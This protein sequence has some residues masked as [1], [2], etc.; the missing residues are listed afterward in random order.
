MMQSQE[1]ST[2]KKKN[3]FQCKGQVSG[4]QVEK[5]VLST[6]ISPTETEEKTEYRALLFTDVWMW[7]WELMK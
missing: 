6:N 4:T 5:V 2:A 3:S 7:L 1:Y